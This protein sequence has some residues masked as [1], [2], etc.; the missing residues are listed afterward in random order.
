MLFGK[1]REFRAPFPLWSCERTLPARH[2]HVLLVCM[3]TGRPP[4]HARASR[5]QPDT[6]TSNSAGMS[7]VFTLSPQRSGLPQPKKRSS[8]KPR[9][10]WCSSY[11]MQRLRSASFDASIEERKG[12]RMNR[13][14][15]QGEGLTIRRLKTSAKPA[16]PTN[17]GQSGG[18]S[19]P[20]QS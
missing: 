11:S 14:T 18:P 20:P 19:S 12:I 9:A 10:L 1:V 16:A 8:L 7:C 4:T 3:Y 13:V 2:A 6:K 5:D 15:G 17:Q